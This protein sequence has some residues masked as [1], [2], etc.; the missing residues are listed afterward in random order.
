MG[1]HRMKYLL[2]NGRI[3]SSAGWYEAD[4]FLE[5]EKITQLGQHLPARDAQVIDV[6]GKYLFPGFVDTHTHFD[7]DAGDFHTADDF[8]SGTQAALAGRTGTGWQKGRHAVI[9][10]SIC[11]LQT[12]TRLCGWN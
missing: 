11:R 9:T 5:G 6:S 10:A 8:F 7:L 3:V 2:K 1:G 12:G 4:L